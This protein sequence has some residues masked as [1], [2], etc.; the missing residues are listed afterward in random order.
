MF[1]LILFF[2]SCALPPLSAFAAC[3]SLLSPFCVD[4]HLS[5]SL[6]G[7]SV[8]SS[9]RGSWGWVPW[10]QFLV[11][12]WQ[13]LCWLDAEESVW[14]NINLWLT[15]AFWA[16]W[17]YYPFPSGMFLSQWHISLFPL[18]VT[19]SF[20]QRISFSSDP[21]DCTEMCLCWSFWVSLSRD[22]VCYFIMWFQAF[23]SFF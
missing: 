23:F 17:R 20:T 5:L 9:H 10:S 12:W 19:Y 6:S 21:I 22:R 16:T 18:L 3:F 14:Q 2:S 4:K 15:F 7:C 1:S 8:C 13:Y 11:C